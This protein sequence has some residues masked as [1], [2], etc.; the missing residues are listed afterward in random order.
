MIDAGSHKTIGSL[1]GNTTSPPSKNNYLAEERD[2]KQKLEKMND[3]ERRL[4][5]LRELEVHCQFT[6]LTFQQRKVIYSEKEIR[7]TLE[8]GEKSKEN[9]TAIFPLKT[10][11]I[12]FLPLIYLSYHYMILQIV[13]SYTV[14]RT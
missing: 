3:I 11:C 12:V 14:R 2:K 7:S 4:A 9:K 13:L 6:L 5:L 8:Q 10:V 1:Y